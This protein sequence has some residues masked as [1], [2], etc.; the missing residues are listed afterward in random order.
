MLKHLLIKLLGI[1]LCFC[2]VMLCFNINFVALIEIPNNIHITLDDLADFNEH[3][4]FGEVITAQVSENIFTVGGE[5]K[6]QSSLSLKLFGFLPIKTIDVIISEPTEVYLGGIPLGF[7]INTNGVIVVGDNQKTSNKNPFK[8]G[9][10][11]SA[12]NGERIDNP[13]DIFRR[14]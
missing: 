3:K 2:F 11:I 9:D 7:S 10:I 5:K 12:V 4:T 6:K 8:T 14:L 1:T 13:K